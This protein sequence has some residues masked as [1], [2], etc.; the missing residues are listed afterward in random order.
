MILND[1]FINVEIYNKNIT[2]DTTLI[3]THG[4]GE[5]SK[6]YV[7]VA[8][9]FENN[10]FQAI[11]YDIRGHG[12]S[13][14]KRGYIKS[15]N[16]FIDDLDSLVRYAYK[17]T[18]KVF[19][20]GH[21]M[22]GL[23]TNLYQ[24]LNNNVDGVIITASPT[25]YLQNMEKLRYFPRFLLN[26][27]KLKTNFYD[28]KLVHDNNY[29]VDG[30]DLTRFYFK[31]INEMLFKGIAKLN[32]NMH[33]YNRKVLLIYSKN[34]K[35]GPVSYGKHFYDNI[36]SEDKELFILENSK[37]NLFNDIEKEVVFNK[38]LD[39]IEEDRKSVV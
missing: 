33:N 10:G 18:K 35:L 34:D 36:N 25:T 31:L 15:Y 19:L 30:Y 12:K 2:K 24:S 8:E 28:E 6:S 39:W 20:V 29:I 1:H 22:G 21:S 17:T 14:G 38:I 11:I 32:K 37:H 3:F 23:I 4:L 9:F 26:K 7:E 16:D 13:E 27:K 5:Y